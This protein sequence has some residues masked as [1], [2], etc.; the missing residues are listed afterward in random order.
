MDDAGLDDDEAVDEGLGGGFASGVGAV[1][2]DV[3]ELAAEGVE[4]GLAGWVHG[5]DVGGFFE[6][7]A[8]CFE[9]AGAVAEVADARSEHVVADGA[10]LEG[11][12][13][14]LDGGFGLFQLGGG[15]VDLVAVSAG[16]GSGLLGLDVDCACDEVGFG[17]E[18]DQG[19]EDGVKGPTTGS[20]A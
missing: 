2:D 17:A 19:V 13:V 16:G 9:G 15:G 6:L 4:V 8:P 20:S 3:F 11:E 18:G 1:G 5:G 7:V 10:G 14:A 12:D